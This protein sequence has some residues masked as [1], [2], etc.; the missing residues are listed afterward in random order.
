VGVYPSTTDSDLYDESIKNQVI[1]E[2]FNDALK[3]ISIECMVNDGKNCRVC[4]PTSRALFTDDVS[5]DVRAMDPCSK[6][7]ESSVTA[8][9]IMYDG[10]KYYYISDTSSVYEYK[11]FTYDTK[12]DAYVILPESDPKYMKIIE[13]IDEEAAAKMK[14]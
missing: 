4:S 5:R 2:S 12:L 11:I 3:E 14:K 10:I 9:E 8:R 1:I 13:V 7:E 6:M